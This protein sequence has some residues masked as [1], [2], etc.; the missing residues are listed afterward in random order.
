MQVPLAPPEIGDRHASPPPFTAYGCGAR[1][2][3]QP[4]R[5]GDQPLAIAE[6]PPSETRRHPRRER[7]EPNRRA[8]IAIMS[9]AQPPASG[10]AIPTGS[11][12]EFFALLIGDLMLWL[13][14]GGR[15]PPDRAEISAA[16]DAPPQRC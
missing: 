4:G 13:R 1:R 7:G 14:L 6:A 15:R 5:A 12:G 2:P 3:H 16:L 10:P 8:L 11:A 9:R